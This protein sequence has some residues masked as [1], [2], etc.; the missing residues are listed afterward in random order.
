MQH[1]FNLIPNLFCIS[2]QALSD[3]SYSR[4][5]IANL[6]WILHSPEQPFFIVQ[7][8]LSLSSEMLFNK[9]PGCF[10]GEN[11]NFYLVLLL[12]GLVWVLVLQFCS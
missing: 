2:I 4:F 10:Q 12:C 11:V 1:E 5:M 8:L 7:S 9:L 3:Q 6:R